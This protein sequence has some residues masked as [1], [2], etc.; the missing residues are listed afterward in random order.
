MTPAGDLAVVKRAG[1]IAAIQASAALAAVLLVV[2]GVVFAVYVRAQNRQ[3]DAELQTLAMSADDAND[4]PPDMELA[5]RGRS[6]DISTS[7]GGQPGVPLLSGPTG[8]GDL[9]T[10]GRHYRTLVVDRAE[11][12]VV[13]MTDLAPY[14][15]GRNR[16]LMSVA[17]AELAGILASIAVVTL[18]TRR[19]VRPLAQALA[20]QRR[21]VADA[22]HELR[23][24]LT[25]LHTRAQMLAQRAG[26]AEP[27][28]IRADA[29]ALVADTRALSD[30]V[31]DLLASAT[32][33]AGDSPRDRV[34]LASVAA[35]V[36]HSLAPYAAALGVS[37]HLEE[38]SGTESFDVVG[39]RAAL[40]RALTALVDN[41][42]GHEHPGGVVDVRLSRRGSMVRAE[43]A[44]DGVGI[45]AGTMATLFT[46]FAHG[47]EHTTRT[48]RPSYG[49]GLALV[50]EIAHA[51]GGDV[52]VESA[53]GQGATFTLSLPAAQTD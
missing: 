8:F 1:R 51:H 2:G 17:F 13:A 44:D 4:P 16:L 27:Q 18:L 15:A 22:S 19:S 25:V 12:R 10:D 39:S 42:L 21:F 5:M 14:G 32:M 50:R 36:Y 49:I 6:G 24:P 35:D 52:E 3:I 48:G 34:D 20:L 37:L 43:V 38:S 7:D 30:I 53:P 28:V 31:D 23:A 26:K 11:G 33:T 46:R 41:A 47:T 29:E 40:R 9:R 45:D